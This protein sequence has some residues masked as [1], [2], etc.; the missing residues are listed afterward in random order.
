MNT[1]AFVLF[2][3]KQKVL[4]LL[5]VSKAWLGSLKLVTWAIG[6]FKC[7]L[8]FPCVSF[9]GLWNFVCVCGISNLILLSLAWGRSVPSVTFSPFLVACHCPVRSTCL[10]PWCAVSRD[11]KLLPSRVGW[12][13]HL[14]L[15]FSVSSG[16]SGWSWEW[17]TELGE[18]A[19]GHRQTQ[20]FLP[21]HCWHNRREVP[22]CSFEVCPECSL[23][24]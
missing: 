22:G 21:F 2:T 10:C 17:G 14:L 5:E 13:N 12:P 11:K 18:T 24:D 16:P 4:I 3:G 19:G 8:N 7:I 20:R 23:K 9:H 1:G 15:P 6:S